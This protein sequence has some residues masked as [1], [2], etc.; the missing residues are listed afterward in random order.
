MSVGETSQ[1]HSS[2]ALSGDNTFLC[3]VA[4]MLAGGNSPAANVLPSVTSAEVSALIEKAKERWR[5]ETDSRMV[6]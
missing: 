6:L 2:T 5:P 1:A 3:E 4:W